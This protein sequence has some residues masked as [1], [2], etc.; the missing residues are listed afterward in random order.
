MKLHCVVRLVVGVVLFTLTVDS[1][2]IKVKGDWWL[3]ALRGVPIH[4][5]P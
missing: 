4:V 3:G 1:S 5:S 2:P